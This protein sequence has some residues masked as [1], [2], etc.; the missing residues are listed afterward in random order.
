MEIQY[1]YTGNI[2]FPMHWYRIHHNTL[3]YNTGLAITLV[4]HAGL[5][6]IK[7]SLIKCLNLQN[8]KVHAYYKKYV[9]LLWFY[10]QNMLLE[11]VLGPN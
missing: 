8:C 3:H 5:H 1:T 6:R 10:Y 4:H 11:A 9:F 2:D 7:T